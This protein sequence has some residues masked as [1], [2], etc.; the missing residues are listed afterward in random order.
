MAFIPINAKADVKGSKKGRLTPAQNAQLN[1]FCLASKTGILDTLDKCEAEQFSYTAI[2]NLATIVFKR[3]YIV[4]CGRLVECEAGTQV[5][6]STPAT[7]SIDG[8]IILRYN[9]SASK[10]EEFEVVTTTE[11]LVQQ[12]LNEN[13]LTGIYEFELYSYTATPSTVT[14]K[15]R[16][17]TNIVPNIHTKISNEISKELN[18]N[19]F[20]V[21]K[22]LYSY[23]NSK[24]TIEQRLTNLGFKTGYVT[25]T[26]MPGGNAMNISQQTIT[27]QGNYVIGKI[28][29]SGNNSTTLNY[30]K[31]T[32]STNFRPKSKVQSL[33][34]VRSYFYG[35]SNSKSIANVYTMYIDTDGEITFSLY[36]KTEITVFGDLEAQINFGFE[37][38]P[39][40]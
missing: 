15:E 32:L 38:P 21:N 31:L 25:R 2:N 4:I 20:S 30:T 26:N 35:Q 10:E 12:D 8:K 18:N 9:L 22:P 29:L 5:R 17:S 11:A 34:G 7:G 13:H 16:T 36:V 3:G 33:V 24:G 6:I 19:F 1:A 27:R 39:I 14:I 37:A 23:N 40:Y 28:T